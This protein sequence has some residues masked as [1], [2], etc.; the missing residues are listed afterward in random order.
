[1]I[2]IKPFL[3]DKFY[4]DAIGKVRNFE[5]TFKLVKSQ[6]RNLPFLFELT[7][8]S[9]SREASVFGNLY[10][11][12]MKMFYAENRENETRNDVVDDVSG[13]IIASNSMENS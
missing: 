1:M 4:N 12:F 8:N 11:K 7:S 3:I 9:F 10:D 5:F 13:S 2:P 6:I